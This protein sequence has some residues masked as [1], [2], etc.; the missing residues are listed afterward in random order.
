MMYLLIAAV[1]LLLIDDSLAYGAATLAG[2]FYISVKTSQEREM[3]SM[4]TSVD[5][6]L[7]DIAYSVATQNTREEVMDFIMAV[8]VLV[9]DYDFTVRLIE[10]LQDALK[11]EDECANG[12]DG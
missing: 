1:A 9:A 7:G 11:K 8:D 12:T 5:L 2:T 3:T 6:E 10:K 4:S